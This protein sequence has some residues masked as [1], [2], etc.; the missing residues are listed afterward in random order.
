[1]IRI[2]KGKEPESWIQYKKTPGTGYASH[3]EL[4]Q[5]LLSEQGYICAYC[6]RRIPLEKCDPG[7]SVTC[8]IEHIKSRSVHEEYAKDY[9]NMIMC[10]PGSIDG[11]AHCDKSKKQR[12]ITLSPFSD[13]L[14]GTISYG[15]GN[16]EIRS[17]NPVWNE[18]INNILCLNNPLLKRNRKDVLTG[19][20]EALGKRMWNTND[21]GRKLQDWKSLDKD[22]KFYPYCGIVIW[23]LEK[24]RK[25]MNKR[26]N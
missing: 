1:M 9:T 24:K 23:F 17:S 7:Q 12:E 2:H 26:R 8:K 16:G 25:Q 5:A 13:E 22:G 11:S 10:C 4:R 3:P 21:I 20:Q 19:V 14:E 18:E 6:M 15:T